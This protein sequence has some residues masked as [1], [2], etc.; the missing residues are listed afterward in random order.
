[1]TRPP[2]PHPCFA[3]DGQTYTLDAMI[4]ANPDDTDF[5]AWAQTA[6]PGDVYEVMH[7]ENVTAVQS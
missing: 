3:M 5:I 1:M 7:A 6:K 4:E 2:D